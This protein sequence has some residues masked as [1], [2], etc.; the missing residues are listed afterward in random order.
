M[1][2]FQACTLM[3]NVF[4]PNRGEIYELRITNYEL[5]GK[6]KINRLCGFIA[7]FRVVRRKNPK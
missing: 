6:V 5:R 4:V 1:L 7:L 3:N 2:F